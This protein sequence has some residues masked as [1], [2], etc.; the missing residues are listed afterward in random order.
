MVPMS[1]IVKPA[2]SNPAELS[3]VNTRPPWPYYPEEVA[4]YERGQLRDKRRKAGLCP[5]CEQPFTQDKL[6]PRRV[7][8]WD[9]S[10]HELVGD[11]GHACEERQ[12]KA[13]P[14]CGRPKGWPCNEMGGDCAGRS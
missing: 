9:F 4:S 8:T 2:L 10:G 5:E 11:C 3:Q 1:D 6:T 14:T 7:S 13:C 12:S